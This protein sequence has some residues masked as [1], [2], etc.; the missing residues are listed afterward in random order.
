[1]IKCDQLRQ[2]TPVLV[3]SHLPYDCAYFEKTRFACRCGMGIQTMA[4]EGSIDAYLHM[5]ESIVTP[6]QVLL[7]KA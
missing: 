7:I 2:T 6:L 1:M 4:Y 5:I 3:S